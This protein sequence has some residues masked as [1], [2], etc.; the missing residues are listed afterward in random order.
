MLLDLLTIASVWVT[1]AGCPS[2]GVAGALGALGELGTLGELGA[3]GAGVGGEMS[4]A[5]TT[6]TEEGKIMGKRS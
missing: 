3:L 5:L 1:D 6:W 2:W 4:L